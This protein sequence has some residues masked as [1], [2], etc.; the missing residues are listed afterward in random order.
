MHR[1]YYQMISSEMFDNWSGIVGSVAFVI[2]V[3]YLVTS[4]V[5][6]KSYFNTGRKE[7]YI[8]IKKWPT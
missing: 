1:L 3:F 5:V 2:Y 8:Y 6:M 4:T 7:S